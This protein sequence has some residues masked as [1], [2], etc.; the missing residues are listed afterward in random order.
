MTAASPCPLAPLGGGRLGPTLGDP[1]Y[2]LAMHGGDLLLVAQLD[3]A[4][5]P[6]R[7]H[8]AAV[9]AAQPTREGE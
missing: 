4:T 3:V 1:T 5:W 8:R 7:V 2:E 6:D 9:L